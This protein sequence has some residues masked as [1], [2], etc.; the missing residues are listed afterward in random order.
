MLVYVLVPNKKIKFKNAFCGALVAMGL[1]WLLRKGFGSF[2]MSNTT[3]ST[4]YGALAII[5]IFLVWMYLCWAVVLF[6]A[7]ITSALDEFAQREK[8]MIIEDTKKK[9]KIK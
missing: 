3:Y 8:K 6:G 2:V 7:V 5:P 4:L 9:Q 1:F